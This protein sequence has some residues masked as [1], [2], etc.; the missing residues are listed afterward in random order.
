MATF[1]FRTVNALVAN[2]GQVCF[3]ATR[4]YVQSGIYDDFLEAYAKAIEDKKKTIGDP[5]KEGTAIGPVVD[6]VQ[7]DRIMGIIDTAKAEKQ[8]TLHS[9]GRQLGSEVRQNNFLGTP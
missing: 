3:A 2:T 9:G 4:V 8:G 5:E 6:K 7:F 1:L